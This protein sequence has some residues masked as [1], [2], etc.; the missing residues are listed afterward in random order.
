MALPPDPRQG[1]TNSL[2]AVQRTGVQLVIFPGESRSSTGVTTGHIYVVGG[3]GESYEM[4]GGPPPGRGYGDRGGHT[5]G[6]T[7]AGQYVLDQQEHH[8]SQNWPASVIPWGAKLRQVDG[9]VQFAKGSQWVNATGPK[10]AVT[11]ALLIFK[12]RSGES[13]GCRRA[14]QSDPQSVLRP[15]GESDSDMEPE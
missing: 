1:K 6:V 14:R 12:R 4:A 7:P 13:R 3:R 9:E 5:A 10:G 11:Q 15:R 2:P 8:T